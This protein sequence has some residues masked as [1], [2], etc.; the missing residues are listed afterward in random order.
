MLENLSLPAELILET[1][2]YLPNDDLEKLAWTNRQMMRIVKRSFPIAVKERVTLDFLRIDPFTDHNPEGSFSIIVQ[3]ERFAW[4][5]PDSSIEHYTH[6][7]VH[8]RN[9]RDRRRFKDIDRRICLAFHKFLKTDAKNRSDDRIHFRQ[10]WSQFAAI[11]GLRSND[12]DD[13]VYGPSVELNW[14]LATT[15][16]QR[17][18]IELELACLPY[19]QSTSLAL[20]TAKDIII[21]TGELDL[22]G[23]IMNFLQQAPKITK[24]RF[25]SF[26]FAPAFVLRTPLE[27]LLDMHADL[28]WTVHPNQYLGGRMYTIH[29]EGRGSWIF[30]ITFKGEKHFFMTIESI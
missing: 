10:S 25:Q 3:I 17:I 8:I 7:R 21:C 18:V 13:I 2:K 27:K 14:L 26:T 19:D 28:S 6:I 1:C 24:W 9:K 15:Y 23:F 29:R 22:N 16:I 12:P 11:K 30:S 4:P 5:L 20:A